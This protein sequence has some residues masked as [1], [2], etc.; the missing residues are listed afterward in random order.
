MKR[1]GNTMTVSLTANMAHSLHLSFPLTEGMSHEGSVFHKQLAEKIAN[2]TGQKY[3]HI[4]LWIRCKLS[5]VI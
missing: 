1:R 3:E 2:K 5:F 4:M